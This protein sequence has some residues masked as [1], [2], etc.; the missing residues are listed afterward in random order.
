MHRRL[1]VLAVALI[2]GSTACQGT[3]KPDEPTSTLPPTTPTTVAETTTTTVSPFA[4]PDVIDIPYVQ[5]V[6]EEIYRLDGEAVRHLYA[7][8]LPDKEFAL[9][10]EAIFGGQTLKES[11][12]ILSERATT[13]LDAFASPPGN[14]TVKARELIQTSVRCMIVLADLSFS[15]FYRSSEVGPS[16][17]SYIYLF[18]AEHSKYN[19]TGWGI[20]RSGRP[21]A[22][23]SG[24]LKCE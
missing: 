11:V 3:T 21:P 7:S 14:P 12:R 24:L 18:R 2:L 13:E 23:Q 1:L 6:L 10:Q 15:P 20:T 17:P 4:V 5:R 22:G 8:K 16:D 9:R 19:S